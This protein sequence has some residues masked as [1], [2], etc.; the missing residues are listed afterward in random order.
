MFTNLLRFILIQLSL[1][2]YVEYYLAVLLRYKYILYW[3]PSVI[4]TEF[5]NFG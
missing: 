5:L 3:L 1:Y 2:Y 4:Y